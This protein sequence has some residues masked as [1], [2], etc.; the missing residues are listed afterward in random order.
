MMKHY[1][2]FFLQMPNHA[3]ES[4]YML[5]Y[6]TINNINSYYY[7]VMEELKSFINSVIAAPVF[8]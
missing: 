7:P 6:R 1:T 5:Y 8:L 3:L 2:T 4:I